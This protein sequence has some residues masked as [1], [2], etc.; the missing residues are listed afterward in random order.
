MRESSASCGAGE[1]SSLVRRWAGSPQARSFQTF[2]LFFCEHT[3][4]KVSRWH[5]G[6]NQCFSVAPTTIRRSTSPPPR[7]EA[8]S[9][10][11][12]SARLRASW[13]HVVMQK[14]ASPP[15]KKNN[16]FLCGT[17]GICQ[18]LSPLLCNIHHNPHNR[19]PASCSDFLELCFD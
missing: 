16:S 18:L 9:R 14:A 1:W 19:C 15:P 12:L 13:S 3:A 10:L 8:N 7:R 17:T 5:R 6:G 2:S 11:V 4:T